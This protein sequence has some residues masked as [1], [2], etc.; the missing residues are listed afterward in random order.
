M[1]NRI[2]KEEL[3]VTNEQFVC[4]IS[5]AEDGMY[6]VAKSILKNDEDCADAIQEAILRAFDKLNT[7][8][9]E[10]YFKTWL[11]RILINECYKILNKKKEEISYE[12]YMQESKET[13]MYS[14]VFEALMSLDEMY[15]IPFVLHY[16]EG[17]STKEISEILNIGVS[18][19][20]IR[21]K[22]ARI[23]L[24]DMLKGE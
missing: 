3:C 17:Y 2:Y 15:R 9:H 5:D 10:N 16:I 13:D 23:K 8:R 12:E 7:L 1:G 21:L 11:T 6:R 20:K 14:E 4:H 24:Q 22:R 19:V 18:N